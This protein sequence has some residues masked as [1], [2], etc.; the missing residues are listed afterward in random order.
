MRN[1]FYFLLI[2]VS[3]KTQAQVPDLF[4][5][6]SVARNAGG[7]TLVNSPVGIR[8][9]IVE[10][11]MTGNVVYTEEHNVVTNDFGLFNLNV[12]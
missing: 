6:Q 4:K 2:F 10:G 5:Y 9:S 12:G 8:V 7:Q 11:S 1:I 3:F